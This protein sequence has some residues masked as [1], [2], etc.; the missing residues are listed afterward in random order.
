MRVTYAVIW[1][2]GDDPERS[3]CLELTPRTL[4]FE[5]SN[6][7][8]GRATKIDY[9]D[10]TNVR[11]GRA[12]DERIDGRPTVMLE[13]SDGDA[14]RIASVAQPG[15]V[16]ELAERLAAL[17]LKRERGMT[18]VAVIVPLVEGAGD[19]ARALLAT[20]P[21]FDPAAWELEEHHV[22]ATDSEVLFVFEAYDDKVLERLA[23]NSAFLAAKSEW[24]EIVAGAPHIV[25]A[26]YSW[27]RPED[28]QTGVTFEPTPGPGDSEGGD[29]FAPRSGAD[30]A[31]DWPRREIS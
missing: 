14:V 26:L 18:R 30:Q 13:R 1:K 29:V 22:F 7:L 4:V 3:G 2:E 9:R 24:M 10:L 16:A 20:G 5:G 21:P 17:R 19:R 12:P 6:G 27:S 31:A 15:I 11:V 25:P 8:G 23:G 28:E